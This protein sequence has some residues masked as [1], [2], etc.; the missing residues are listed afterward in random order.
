MS[1]TALLS[2]YAGEAEPTF[3]PFTATAGTAAIFDS[4]HSRRERER[5]RER[6]CVR[7]DLAYNVVCVQF[8]LEKERKW[9]CEIL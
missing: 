6:Q 9:V 8:V 2:R 3:T 4:T 5:E 1:F 7:V